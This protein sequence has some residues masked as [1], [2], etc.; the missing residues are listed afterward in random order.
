MGKKIAFQ[1]TTVDVSFW[2]DAVNKFP[3]DAQQSDM[4]CSI[5]FSIIESIFGH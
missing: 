2:Q 4:L 5:L 1:G 3:G